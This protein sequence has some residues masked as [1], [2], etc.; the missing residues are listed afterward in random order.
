MREGRPA[1]V[2]S[3]PLQ[4][5]ISKAAADAGEF[6]VSKWTTKSSSVKGML[7]WLR[8]M[9][10]DSGSVSLQMASEALSK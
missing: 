10:E 4:M 8:R 7:A 3:L 2:G 9:P 5:L 1:V 6:N